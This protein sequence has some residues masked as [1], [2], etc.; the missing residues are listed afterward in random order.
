MRVF[1]YYFK[2]SRSAVGLVPMQKQH[3]RN[4]YGHH[5]GSAPALLVMPED[6]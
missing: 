6:E 2:G 4:R 3:D 1:P 5:Y